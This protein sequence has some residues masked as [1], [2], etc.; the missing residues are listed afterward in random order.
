MIYGYSE[1][2]IFNSIIY[3]LD[4]R[5]PD[6]IGAFIGT[7]GVEG[8]TEGEH[9]F[10]FLNEQSFSDFGDND[11]TIV[12]DEDKANKTVVF[13]EGKVKTYTGKYDLEKEKNKIKNAKVPFNGFSS[14]IFVQLYYKFLLQKAINSSEEDTRNLKIDD[15][16]KKKN[17]VGKIVE[18]SIGDNGVV[19]KACER[20]KAT[21]YYYV[22]LLPTIKKRKDF[23]EMFE[24]VNQ[25]LKEKM[26]IKNIS[27]VY[28]GDIREFFE[29]KKDATLIHENFRYN[30]TLKDE[31]TQSQIYS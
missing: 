21:N 12:I 4:L 14:N 25:N 5:R 13:C 15:I 28:W 26:E 18:R 10:T 31:K 20:I 2:G 9:K 8:F 7:L 6:L 27:C 24:E 3:Y 29:D 30:E 16:Y 22:A 1:R 11:L 23:Q 17:R 19:R